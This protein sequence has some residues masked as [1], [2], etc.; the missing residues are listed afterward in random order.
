MSWTMERDGSA[1]DTPPP[2]ELAL[3]MDEYR[4]DSE[5]RHV[6]DG[7]GGSACSRKRARPD[8]DC[9]RSGMQE[10][11]KVVVKK[12]VGAD[13]EEEARAAEDAEGCADQADADL[14]WVDKIVIDGR[15]RPF[16]R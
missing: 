5:Q 2:P 10:A 4:R 8:A 13:G 11:F 16:I 14:S 15:A 3:F 7:G 9:A 12:E 1:V 6:V